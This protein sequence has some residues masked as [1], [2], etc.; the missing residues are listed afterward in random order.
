[1]A[2]SKEALVAFHPLKEVI[3]AADRAITAE[4]F[5]ALMGLYADDATLVVKPGMHAVG[6]EQIRRAFVAIADH[7][8]HSLVVKQG[9]MV[10][11]E[12][13]DT[14]LVL[15]ESIIEATGSDGLATTTTRQGTYVFRKSAAGTWL[16]VIDN[17]YGT[18][19]LKDDHTT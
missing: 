17:S 4:D 10:V 18:D 6:K 14:A 13:G 9:K 2:R 1:M 15:M 7:F 16:C 5:D 11:L 8:N 19:L 3:E 12:G